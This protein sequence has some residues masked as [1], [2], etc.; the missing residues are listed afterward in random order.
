LIGKGHQFKS[1]TDTEVLIHL[2]EE[3]REN[4][5]NRLNGMFALAIWDVREN[6]L[7]L[8]RDRI[9]K[10]PLFYRQEQGRVFIR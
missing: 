6:Q 5:F 7:L 8:G 9:G 1:C 2:Y 4:M 10:K 3:E